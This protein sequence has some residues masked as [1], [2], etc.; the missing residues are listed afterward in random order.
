MPAT[1]AE[2]VMRCNRTFIQCLYNICRT[3]HIHLC[4]VAK[5]QEW[6]RVAATL[7][8]GWGGDEKRRVKQVEEE[9]AYSV[10]GMFSILT[11][12]VEIGLYGLI[13]YTETPPPT[14]HTHIQRT[15]TKA[16]EI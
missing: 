14:Y 15:V 1:T 11:A 6:R 10:G 12:K 8:L 4:S 7:G 13:K 2:T 5:F 3:L 9:G 16:E